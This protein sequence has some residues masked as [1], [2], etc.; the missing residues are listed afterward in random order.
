[1]KNTTAAALRFE[2][3]IKMGFVS[4]E[5]TQSDF[6]DE[7]YNTASDR[8]ELKEKEGKK[9]LLIDGEPVAFFQDGVKRTELSA[10]GA[11]ANKVLAYFGI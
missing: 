1:M 10:F 3:L 7:A 5:N 8:A 9:L 6:S 2:D 4:S 11:N